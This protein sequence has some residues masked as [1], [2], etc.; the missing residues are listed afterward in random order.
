MSGD[1]RRSFLK[2]ICF[3]T[4]YFLTINDLLININRLLTNTLMLFGIYGVQFGIFSDV[5]RMF[6]T[7]VLALMTLVYGVVC[8]L[9][10][11]GVIKN[12]KE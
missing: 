2:F 4:L 7:S 8:L 6:I 9:R 11:F 3:G 1:I 12:H 10:L 5:L